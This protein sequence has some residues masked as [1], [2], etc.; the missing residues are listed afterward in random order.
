VKDKDFF[1]LMVEMRPWNWKS[2][3]EGEDFIEI[4]NG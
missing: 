1:K 3:V 2:E 4:G